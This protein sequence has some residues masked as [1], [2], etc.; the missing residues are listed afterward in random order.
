MRVPKSALAVYTQIL[1]IEQKQDSIAAEKTL[2]T[3]AQLNLSWFDYP[4]AIASYNQLLSIAKAKVNRP[5]ELAYLR[6]LVY[7]MIERN[8]V[9]KQ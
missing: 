1:A 7:I 8:N 3:I 2:Q 4:Q 5:N 9:S 6:Q